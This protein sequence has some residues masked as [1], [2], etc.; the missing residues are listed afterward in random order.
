[1]KQ[2]SYAQIFPVVYK[3]RCHID[4][5]FVVILIARTSYNKL[6]YVPTYIRNDYLSFDIAINKSG[7]QILA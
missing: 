2:L 1:M 5:F 3:L 7:V 4:L 6:G